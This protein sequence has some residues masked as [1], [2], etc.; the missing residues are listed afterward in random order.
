MNVPNAIVNNL[1]AKGI[2]KFTMQR[3]EH[4]QYHMQR[5]QPNEHLNIS[6]GKLYISG[7]LFPYH[8]ILVSQNRHIHAIQNA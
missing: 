7:N 4:F 2:R 5:A 1:I 3:T 8:M 6:A